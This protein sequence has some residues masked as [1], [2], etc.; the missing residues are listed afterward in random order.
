M[1]LPVNALASFLKLLRWVILSLLLSLIVLLF[2]RASVIQIDQSIYYTIVSN[3]IEHS[4]TDAEEQS[5]F[6]CSKIKNGEI[7]F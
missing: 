6:V 1:I 7:T 2:F 3:Q 4:I 5:L